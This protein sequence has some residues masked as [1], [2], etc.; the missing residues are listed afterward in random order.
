ML[1]IDEIHRLPAAVEEYIYPAM[2]EFKVDFVVD[3]GMHSRTINLPLKP[4]TLIGATTRAG[5]LSPPL[6]MRF[7]ITQHL[8]FWSEQDLLRRL[9]MSAEMLQILY[10][11][12]A[13]ELMARRPRR[14]RA[15]KPI[16]SRNGSTTST[17]VSVSS[18]R[19]AAT[20]SMPTGPPR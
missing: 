20:A 19:V 7:G 14:V 6:R 12:E 2:E 16:C 17:R 1:F 3:S 9:K 5:L 4:F 10:T 15:R 11:E 13:L 8:D 18:P